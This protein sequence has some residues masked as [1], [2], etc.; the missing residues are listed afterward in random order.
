MI[1]KSLP[2]PL[3]RLADLFGIDSP[4]HDLREATVVVIEDD[5]RC[6]EVI[7]DALLGKQEVVICRSASSSS[8]CVAS[9]AAPSSLTAIGLILDA[10]GVIGTTSDE[11]RAA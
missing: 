7:V 4:V 1:Q 11:S 6:A 10:P 2:L 8:A 3:I 9:P 5:G